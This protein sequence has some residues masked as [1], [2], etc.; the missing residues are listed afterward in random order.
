MDAV[1]QNFAFFWTTYALGTVGPVAG[2]LLILSRSRMDHRIFL[3]SW[4]LWLTGAGLLI[5]CVWSVRSIFFRP[6]N[7]RRPSWIYPA[8]SWLA[9]LE[10]LTWAFAVLRVI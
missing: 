5:A 6:T 2:N 9:L 8:V 1:P 4:L 7:I 3:F 10:F